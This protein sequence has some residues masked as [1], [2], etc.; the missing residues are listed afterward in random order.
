MP[1]VGAGKAEIDLEGVL[2]FDGFDEQLDVI[3]A[4]ALVVGAGTRCCVVSVEATSLRG[5]LVDLLRDAAAT[6]SSCPREAT[7]VCATHTFSVPHVRTP[8]HLADDEERVRNGRLREALVGA[9]EKAAC[10]AAESLRDAT[11]SVACGVTGV[12]VNRDVDTPAGWWV[13]TNPEGYSDH[14]VRALVARGTTD[15]ATM[16]VVFSADVQSSVLQGSRDGEGRRLVTGDLAG[17]AAA[18]V[19]SSSPGCVALFLEGAAADQAPVEQAVVTTVAH[20]GSISRT[21]GGDAGL[22]LLDR[23]GARLGEDVSSALAQATPLACDVIEA[24]EAVVTCPGQRRAD[25]ASLRPDRDYSFRAAPDV[26]TTMCVLRLGDLVLLG[27]APE[28]P[29]SLGTLVRTGRTTALVDILTL[30]N[31]AEKYLPARDAYERRTYEAM[32]SGFGEGSAEALLRA[33]TETVNN[34]LDSRGNDELGDRL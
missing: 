11:L 20:D 7:W 34:A 31:G 23:L 4:R 8:E 1:N 17:R 21:D 27:I 16:A 10:D 26:S 19:E 13:G 3:W 12:N 6:A 2:P 28:I 9:V 18:Y 15:G 25:F 5:D 32:N 33:A 22:A 29:S 14:G 30:V 24:T